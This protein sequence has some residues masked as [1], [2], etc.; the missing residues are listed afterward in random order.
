M[1]KNHTY[2]WNL[3][4]LRPFDFQIQLFP[5][6]AVYPVMDLHS[7]IHLNMILDGGM[8][9]KIGNDVFQLR[10]YD[11][12]ITAPWELHGE[13]RIGGRLRLLAITVDS[14]M[15]LSGLMEYRDRALTLFMLEP[16][17]RHRI[18]NSEAARPLRVEAASALPSI[19]GDHPEILKLRRWFAIQRLFV[20][21]LD[22]IPA[23]ELPGTSSQVFRKILPAFDLLKEGRRITL[24]EASAACSLSP[25]RFSHLFRML[26]RVSF[27]AYEIRNRLNHAA[28]LLRQG[29]PVKIAADRTGFFDSSH[30]IRHFTKQFGMTPGKFR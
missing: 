6:P 15:L 7:S 22:R 5:G 9:G 26:C 11:L 23:N 20:E 14:E 16:R 10:Q 2:Y 27:A 3:S 12:Q 17:E 19:A 25:D 18:L 29:V 28:F 4:P 13:N 21:L 30:F 24:Q 8:T 1:K